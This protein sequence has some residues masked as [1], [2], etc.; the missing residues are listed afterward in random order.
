MG[1]MDGDLIGLFALLVGLELILGVDNVLVIAILVS[2]LPENKRNSTRNFGLVLA[3][4][5]RVIMVLGGLKLIQL[6]NPAWTDGPD[7]FAYSWRD[8]ALLAG[9]LFLMWKAVKEIHATVELEHHETKNKAKASLGGII[10]QIV[11]LDIVFSL[12]SVIT[13][14]GLT[15]N[16]WIIIT[17]VLSSFVVILFFAKPIGDFIMKNVALK[18]L[19]LS[20]LIVI[21]ITIFMEGLGK[22]VEKSMIYVPMGFALAIQLLQMRHKKNL[23]QIKNKTS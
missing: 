7:W 15:D 9:G 12:D 5:A 16:Q 18:I 20:F 6:T 22:E 10:F 19:A 13:A 14:V 3:M 23:N 8:L 17:A 2:R 1:S 4:V 11:I 21:G